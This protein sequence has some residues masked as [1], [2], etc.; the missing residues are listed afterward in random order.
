MKRYREDA[1]LPTLGPVTRTCPTLYWLT[2]LLHLGVSAAPCCSCSLCADRCC[3]TSY[4][5]P[6][7]GNML[8]HVSFVCSNTTVGMLL[9]D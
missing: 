7:T 4:C 1:A 6:A 9:Y 3:A 5:T 8:V 2:R